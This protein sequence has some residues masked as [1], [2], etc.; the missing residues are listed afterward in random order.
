MSIN[1]QLLGTMKV[2]ENGNFSLTPGKPLVDFL[3]PGNWLMQIPWEVESFFTHPQCTKDHL[4]HLNLSF[5]IIWPSLFNSCLFFVFSHFGGKRSSQLCFTLGWLQSVYRG[6]NVA[7]TFQG[8]Y[9]ADPQL[10]A[11]VP[12]SYR[13]VTWVLPHQPL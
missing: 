1:L 11:G 5:R 7:I 10:L 6:I 4:S 13:V 3:T 12:L 2:L 8:R 9:M